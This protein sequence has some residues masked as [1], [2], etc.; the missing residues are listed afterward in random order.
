MNT[1]KK[2]SLAFDSFKGSAT[3][4]QIAESASRAIRAHIPDCEIVS[5]PVADGGEGTTAA[6]CSKIRTSEIKCKVHG[7]LMEEITVSYHITED[8]SAAIMEM[9]AAS[10]LP[11][12]P[13][14]KRNPRIATSFGTGEMILDAAK[15]GCKKILL[16]IGGSA[17]NDAGVGMLK[18]LGYRFTDARGNDTSDLCAIE[19]FDCSGLSASLKG[20]EFDVIC[21]VTNPFYGKNGA[22]HV[23]APQKGAGPEDVEYLDKGL[24]HF[25]GVV[26][27]DLALDLQT[28]SGSG[29]AGGM[30]G[31][32]YAFLGAKLM[33]GIDA[34]LNMLD[35][36]AALDGAS[37][38][39]TGEGKI[40]RQ[41]ASM[42]KALAG[43]LARADRF[44]VPVVALAGAVEN[45]DDLNALGFRA[46]LS[47][48]PRPVSLE[49]AMNTEN[50]LE[51]IRKTVSQV[52]RL[53]F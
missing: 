47:I 2:I 46:V 39:L 28:V 7:P 41:T 42:G 32:L 12:V 49:E 9:A 24:E 25:A 17:T 21:D 48:Q 30:G 4:Q 43:I 15:R 1:G 29:A 45:A 40:D 8:G 44:G 50:T 22:A 27:R 31:G 26:K 5:V 36:D 14:E 18:A 11:L 16:G 33:P 10:G 13:A 52:V 53:M 6:I 19:S 37:L 38:V 51:N 3:S 20:V 23:F 34:I 35:F